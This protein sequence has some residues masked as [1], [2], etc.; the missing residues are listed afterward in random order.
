MSAKPFIEDP[1]RANFGSFV[2]F[3]GFLGRCHAHIYLGRRASRQGQ[4][5]IVNT[6]GTLD[7][8]F[9]H[10]SHDRFRATEIARPVP[11]HLLPLDIRR[12]P[13]RPQGRSGLRI[14]RLNGY[15]CAIFEQPYTSVNSH[16]QVRARRGGQCARGRAAAGGGGGSAQ[17]LAPRKQFSR[18]SSRRPRSRVQAAD[19]PANE[20]AKRQPAAT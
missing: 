7:G 10:P 17:L 8:I 16:R 9:A 18:G 4:K 11:N 13:V 3:R 14:V 5:V 12:E 15:F 6:K 2:Q 1:S 19:R 20:L